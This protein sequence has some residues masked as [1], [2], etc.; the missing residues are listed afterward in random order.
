MSEKKMEVLVNPKT[1]QTLSRVGNGTMQ[2]A[3]RVVRRALRRAGYDLTLVDETGAG[4]SFPPDFDPAARDLCRLVRP[5]TMT[6]PE[7]IFALRQSVQYLVQHEVPGDIVE[8]GVWKGGSMMAVALTLQQ[9][10]IRDRNLHLFDTFEGMSAPTHE[11][12]SVRGESAADLLSKSADEAESSWVWACSALD[13]V[14]SNLQTT[15]YPADRLLFVKGKVEDTIPEHAPTRI[16]LLRLDTDWY[17]STYH[18]LLHLFPRLSPGGVLIIDDYGHWAGARK[19]VD[20]YFFEHHLQPLLHRID[21]TCRMCVKSSRVFI[22]PWSL[23]PHNPVE[24]VR[25]SFV[26]EIGTASIARSHSTPRCK[27]RK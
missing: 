18:E 14:M 13:E 7:R 9:L 6:S 4:P 1:F 25:R 21:Y 12:V 5:F 16:A 26:K 15:S 20:Q 10:G 22:F 17:E 11:D 24:T 27:F 23:P 19:A 2:L 8:C 3:K